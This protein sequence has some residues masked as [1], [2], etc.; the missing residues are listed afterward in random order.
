M[1]CYKFLQ[2]ATRTTDKRQLIFTLQV[3]EQ[4]TSP[5][6]FVLICLFRQIVNTHSYLASFFFFKE[7]KKNFVLFIYFLPHYNNEIIHLKKMTSS[8]KHFLLLFIFCTGF[9]FPFVASSGSDNELDSLRYSIDVF[10]KLLTALNITHGLYIPKDRLVHILDKIT[11]RYVCETKPTCS[12]ALV[13]YF[14]SFSFH[15]R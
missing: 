7:K 11:S 1:V 5:T 14:Y 8:T 4:I 9:F 6:L 13:R 2:S 12:N 3:R 10:R 15:I